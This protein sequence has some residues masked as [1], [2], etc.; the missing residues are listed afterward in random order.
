M[1]PPKDRSPHDCSTHQ[2]SRGMSVSLEL[3][4]CYDESNGARLPQA[5]QHLRCISWCAQTAKADQQLT[6]AVTSNYSELDS[7]SCRLG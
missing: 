5:L 7:P 6:P 4:T 2:P 1:H 3:Y